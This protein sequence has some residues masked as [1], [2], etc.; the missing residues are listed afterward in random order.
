ML[1]E[2]MS[3]FFSEGDPGI[4]FATHTDSAGEQH[5]LTGEFIN[6]TDKHHSGSRHINQN[7]PAFKLPAIHAQAVEIE[8]SVLID[9]VNYQVAEKLDIANGICLLYLVNKKSNGGPHR[10]N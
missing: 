8:D 9:D 4:E 1:D 3:V 6:N 2:D 10:W 5:S 7:E